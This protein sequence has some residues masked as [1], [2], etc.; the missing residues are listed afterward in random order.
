M[1]INGGGFGLGS[2][3]ALA[4]NVIMNG[5]RLYGDGPL[6]ELIAM[7][8]FIDPGFGLEARACSSRKA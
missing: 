2:G 8:G 4:S 5:G 3:S 7:G 1:T 6:G